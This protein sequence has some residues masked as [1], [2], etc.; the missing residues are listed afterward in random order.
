[1]EMGR[2]RCR[3][4]YAELNQGRLLNE[5]YASPGSRGGCAEQHEWKR[6]ASL[7]WHFLLARDINV[8]CFLS[9]PSQPFL[10]SNSP[11]LLLNLP[12]L[13]PL[14]LL[15]PFSIWTAVHSLPRVLPVVIL[16]SG[17]REGCE[18]HEDAGCSVTMVLLDSRSGANA[19]DAYIRFVCGLVCAGASAS[20]RLES[21]YVVSG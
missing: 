21:I 1:M 7:K 12:L 18:T 16:L 11:H 19:R 4:V 17:T 2:G 8:R 20:T 6:D 10:L 13:L 9:L 14:H 5:V 3:K 15:P